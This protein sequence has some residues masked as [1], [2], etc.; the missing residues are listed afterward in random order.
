[1][2]MLAIIVLI[3]GGLPFWS[4]FQLQRQGVDLCSDQLKPAIHKPTLW[5]TKLTFNFYLLVVF[6]PFSQESCGILS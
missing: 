6:L 2:S 1:M 5:Q 4:L 3:V